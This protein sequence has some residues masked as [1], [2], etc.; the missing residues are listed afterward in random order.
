MMSR[1]N[2]DSITRLHVFNDDRYKERLFDLLERV[3]LQVL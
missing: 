2:Y 1:H 3:R